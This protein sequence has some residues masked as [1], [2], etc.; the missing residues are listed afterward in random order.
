MSDQVNGIKDVVGFS[1]VLLS[2]AAALASCEGSD[3]TLK[4]SIDRDFWCV[5]GIREVLTRLN[6]ESSAM[7]LYCINKLI[8]ALKR[9][10]NRINVDENPLYRELCEESV[11][12]E[13][14]TEKP[15]DPGPG[16][17][18]VSA[19]GT[20]SAPGHHYPGMVGP[21]NGR[22]SSDSVIPCHCKDCLMEAGAEP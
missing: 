17:G 10:R 22:R 21:G 12:T 4:Q 6:L 19:C 9:V 1:T 7:D 8:D 20:I 15:D 13:R 14:D 16:E 2:V 18:R 5:D 11:E 3:K